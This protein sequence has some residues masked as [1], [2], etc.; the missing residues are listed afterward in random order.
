MKKLMMF[1]AAAGL[2]ASASCTRDDSEMTGSGSEGIVTLSARLPQQLQTRSMGDGLTATKL[3]YA[4]YEAGAKTPLLTSE[5]DGAPVV[6][7]N[8]LQAQLTLR[9][10]TGRSYDVLFWADAFGQKDDA[11]PYKV[12]FEAQSVTVDYDAALSNDESRDAFFGTIQGMEV[13]SA[14]S[15]E[16]VLT[17]PFA[18]INVGTDDLAVA[19]E[20]GLLTDA[21]Q[22][23]MKLS[24]VPTML[25]LMDG[26]TSGSANVTFAANAI[27]TEQLTVSGKTYDYL[28]MNYLLI[29]TDKTTTN[30]A[31]TFSDGATSDNRSF[32]NVP[33]QR[34]YRTNIVGS[35]LT[36]GVDF[37]IEIDPGFGDPDHNLAAL[38]MA[39]ENGGSVTLT[40]DVELPRTLIVQAG[41]KLTVDLGG[42]EIRYTGTSTGGAID[43]YG[44]L[45]IR[46]EGVV[47]GGSNATVTAVAAM[48]ANAKVTIYGGTYKVG[49][50]NNG[51]WNDCI[52]AYNGGE[53]TIYGGHFESA[54]ASP[55]GIYTVLN[56]NNSKP[57]TITVYGGEFV[58][59]DP[60]TGDPGRGGNFVAEG[61]S[62]ILVNDNPNTWRV[63]KN[64]TI[65][66]EADLAEA[67]AD[68]AQNGGEVTI[69]ASASL[70]L[71]GIE[72]FSIQQPTVITLDGTVENSTEWM[73]TNDSKLTL[74]GTGTYSC[75]KGIVRNN[76]DLTVEGGTWET[77]LNQSGTAFY[78]NSEDAVLTLKNV[79][80]NAAFFAVAGIGTIQIEGG[81]ISSTSSNKYGSW[82]Y[83]IRAESNC[84][85]T[86]KDV[87]V[88]G[89]QGAIAA[90]D[91]SHVVCDNVTV[92][93]RNSEPGLSDAFYALYAASE[94]V[95]EVLSGNYYSDRT[96]CALA[97]N[98]DVPDNP[99]GGFILKGGRFSSQPRSASNQPWTPEEGYTYV[100]TG[101]SVYPYEIVAE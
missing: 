69:P 24:N 55:D 36:Q 31:F 62:S 59:Y 56:V 73:I 72:P 19:A 94:G 74:R 27:P 77:T 11:T 100:E 90:I 97:S 88:E 9:L 18:Q 25:N 3:T 40:E 13:T 84:R 61:Y 53:I 2:M 67:M 35:V 26:T 16:V 47:D 98:D 45:V 39:A 79:D 76:G 65:S 57:G 15:Q 52:Y 81:S 91:G 75:P 29:G 66:T 78:N 64:H 23:E 32:S 68:I 86:L 8:N 82:A 48:G 14:T 17:R 63:V 33:V 6:E 1:L 96:P 30:I 80:L 99:L 43:V 54:V 28:A 83:T 21:L 89:V 44:E 38:L 71:D 87:T 12:D 93:T 7:F 4:V 20:S 10:T 22:T 101:D 42:Q 34:N 51:E 41:K 49:A 60:A 70:K 95:I 5:S 50:D 92:A 37:D 85:M 58:N 46:G